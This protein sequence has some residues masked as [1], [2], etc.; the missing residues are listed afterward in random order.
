MRKQI[1][2]LLLGLVFLSSCKEEPTLVKVLQF[3]VW[4]EGTVLPGGFDAIVDE[5]VKSKADFV[6]LSEVRNYH[7]TRFCDRIVKALKKRGVAY[8]SFFSDDSGILSRYP[9]EDSTVVY[10]LRNDQ[11]SI[12]RLTTSIGKR[13]F[14]IYTAHLDYRHC[15]YYDVRGYDGCSWRKREPV[16][17]V[18]SVLLLNRASVRDDAIKKFIIQANLDRKQGFYV[19]LGGDFNEPSHLDW[20][21]E[22][23][24][25][26]DHQGLVIPWDVS[27]LLYKH[28]YKDAYRTFFKDPLTHP[29]FTYPAD[30]PLAKLSQLTWAPQADER[31][32][33]DF[34]YFYPKEGLRIIDASIVGPLGD[35][36]K[37]KRMITKS[38]DKVIKPIKNWPSDHKAVLITFSID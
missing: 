31:E 25:L 21:E 26:H 14:A 5:I 35:I 23:K 12:Y 33:I 30:N 4:Q 29:G 20:I 19:F 36:C 2:V 32:R 8:Y 27:S 38:E 34:I 16:T 15:A 9:I 22:N 10:P 28:G 11:G 13:K 7:K 6:T 1:I 3:N 37:S 24:N 17:D 18:D